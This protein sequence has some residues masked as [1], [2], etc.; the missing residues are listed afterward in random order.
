[1]IEEDKEEVERISSKVSDPSA[2]KQTSVSQLK[3]R[4]RVRSIRRLSLC[5]EY[6]RTKRRFL[7][8]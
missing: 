2:I 5:L 6:R 1:M 3:V 4:Q 8:N 7:R